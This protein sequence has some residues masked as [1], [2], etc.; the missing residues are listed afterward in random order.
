MVEEKKRTDD[1]QKNTLKVNLAEHAA[2]KTCL[3][4]Q[5]AEY[6]TKKQGFQEELKWS[7]WRLILGT[8]AISIALT[9]QFY[10]MPFPQSR[11][12]LAACVGAY[13]ILQGFLALIQQ[14]LGD[15]VFIS[16]PIP[17]VQNP[18]AKKKDKPTGRP[19]IQVRATIPKYETTYTVTVETLE[20]RPKT[21][22]VD[23]DVSKFFD[24]EGTYLQDKFFQELARLYQKLQQ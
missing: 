3:D 1:D 5:I 12:F 21:H 8:I 15:T 14:R 20:P 13:V 24:E 2:V 19:A 7:N 17:G 6:F 9:A 16:K 23:L 11:W 4:E 22:K 10:P 18:A